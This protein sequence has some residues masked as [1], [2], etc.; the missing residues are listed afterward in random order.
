MGKVKAFR[1][2]DEISELL[3]KTAQKT[4]RTETFYVVEALK[5]YFSEYYDYQVAK[6]RF[7]DPNDEIITSKEMRERLGL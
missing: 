6:D 1:L 5:N 2:P 7:E 3:E 4:D